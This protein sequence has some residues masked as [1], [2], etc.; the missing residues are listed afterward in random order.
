MDI[1]LRKKYYKKVKLI[2]ISNT[3]NSNRFFLRRLLRNLDAPHISLSA[4]IISYFKNNRITKN[5]FVSIESVH[6]KKITKNYGINFFDSAEHNYGN[7]FLTNVFPNPSNSLICLYIRDSSY[8]KNTFPKSNWDYHNYRDS[9]AKDYLYLV[10]SLV[11]L[12]F[13]VIRMGRIAEEKLNFK[14]LNFYDYPFSKLKSDFLDIWIPQQAVAIISNGTGPDMLALLFNKP[15]L[16]INYLPAIG[17]FFNHKFLGAPK[18]ILHTG[19]KPNLDENLINSRYRTDE[20]LKDKLI[21]K[22]IPVEMQ[23]SLLKEFMNYINNSYPNQSHLQIEA[24]NK[25]YL[26]RKDIMGSKAR[27]PFANLSQVWLNQFS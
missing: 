12:N 19:L 9:K 25:I 3:K 5:L 10:K 2:L 23:K 8:L 11:A 17:G 6:N 26:L 21:I 20:Y 22:N 18:M 13:N 16:F 1:T 7:E 14:N 24:L 4:K 27:N 15:L